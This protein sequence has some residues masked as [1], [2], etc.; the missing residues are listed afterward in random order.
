MESLRSLNSSEGMLKALK[1][2]KTISKISPN[3]YSQILRHS[4]GGYQGGLQVVYNQT[5]KPKPVVEEIE[6]EYQKNEQDLQKFY[7]AFRYHLGRSI[8][9]YREP[10]KY[11][12]E[13][14]P[15]GSLLSQKRGRQVGESTVC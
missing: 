7:K 4:G 9:E 3:L 10:P 2:R 6:N 5:K 15:Q 13:Q 12:L 8:V 1:E 14:K 11:P